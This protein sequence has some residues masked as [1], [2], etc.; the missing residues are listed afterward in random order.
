MTQKE[1]ETTVPGR[2]TIEGVN[3]EGVKLRFREITD[4]S[5]TL[6]SVVNLFEQIIRADSAESKV[7]G[8]KWSPPYSLRFLYL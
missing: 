4:E 8:D 7:G 3:K 1:G 6:R 2:A 5:T